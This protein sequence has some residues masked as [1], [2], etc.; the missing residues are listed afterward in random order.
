[1]LLR[2]IIVTIKRPQVMRK[3]GEIE[4]AYTDEQKEL[5]LKNKANKKITFGIMEELRILTGLSF[6][7]LEIYIKTAQEKVKTTTDRPI[8]DFDGRSRSALYRE[9][10]KTESK[11]VSELK[12]KSIEKN[13]GR[14][15]IR[16]I[17]IPI[18]YGKD[19]AEECDIKKV[20]KYEI[21]RFLCCYEVTTSYFDCK[22]INKEDFPPTKEFIMNYVLYVQ[23]TLKIPFDCVIFTQKLVDCDGSY[24]NWGK[25]SF[26][27]NEVV[28]GAFTKI[29]QLECTTQP[30]KFSICGMEKKLKFTNTI[31]AI[32]EAHYSEIKSKIKKQRQ[33]CSKVYADFL[34]R[35]EEFEK[36]K[37]QNEYIFEKAASKITAEEFAISQL[38]AKNIER[39]EIV[40]FNSVV[41]T[42]KKF[43][44]LKEKIEQNLQS[45][46]DIE[47]KKFLVRMGLQ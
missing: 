8:Y 9:C 21:L 33:V 43:K 10:K 36:F 47:F 44:K 12:R 1:M 16:I 2:I 35:M 5:A 6:S 11:S 40:T 30:D 22:R 29:E 39:K 32:A 27:Q 3:E 23:S 45:K 17:E 41:L 25:K 19:E 42:N 7:K 26:Q 13:Y 18:F 4:M 28:V 20:R 31:D 15:R 24:W 46:S 37:K 34:K 38:I 14:L